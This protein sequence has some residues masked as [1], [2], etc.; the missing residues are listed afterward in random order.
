[1]G[2]IFRNLTP[3][4]LCYSQVMLI[5]SVIAEMSA[6]K[7]SKMKMVQI[8][9]GVPPWLYW[10]SYFFQF[11]CLALCASLLWTGVFLG[12]TA[13]DCGPLLVFIPI[14]LSHI[15]VFAVGV[16]V[17][18]VANKMQDAVGMANLMQVID[19]THI[20]IIFKFHAPTCV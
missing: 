1:M 11:E 12:T 17:C 14:F 16:M 5:N 10:L 19:T 20:L 15:Q 2:T 9:N 3:F 13:F 7:E 6:E 18:A 8:V 4:M